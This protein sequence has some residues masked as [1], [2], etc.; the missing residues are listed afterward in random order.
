MRYTGRLERRDLAG[1]VWVLH[2]PEG[3]KSLYGEVPRQLEGQRVE[4]EGEA[5][6][7]FGIGMTGPGITVR[8]VRKA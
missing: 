6:E 4:V 8:T 7:A 1:G 5:E 2:T 3:E